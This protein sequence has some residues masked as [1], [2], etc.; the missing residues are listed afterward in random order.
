MKINYD[1][2]SEDVTRWLDAKKIS[3]KKRQALSTMSDNMIDAIMEGKL[4]VE[5]DNTLTQILDFPD[6]GTEKLSYKLR[7]SPIDLEGPKK[8]VKGDSWD[9]NLT[10]TIMAITNTNVNVVRKLDSS[11]DRAIAES[12]ATFFL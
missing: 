7:I 11:T 10:R 6:A 1:T 5:D 12:I 3:E 8:L 4:I 2:A 9:D